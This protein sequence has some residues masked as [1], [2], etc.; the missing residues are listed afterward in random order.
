[1][2][3]DKK[4]WKSEIAFKITHATRNILVF[5]YRNDTWTKMIYGT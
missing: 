4:S 2:E 1:M 3:S 5:I